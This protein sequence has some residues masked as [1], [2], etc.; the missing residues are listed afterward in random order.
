MFINKPIKTRT[1]RATIEP[2]DHRIF[3]RV[4]FR[5]HI[6]IIQFLAMILIYCHI[7]ANPLKIT[8]N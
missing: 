7:P 2:K 3:R 4:S 1:T 8:Q 6:I 5:Q